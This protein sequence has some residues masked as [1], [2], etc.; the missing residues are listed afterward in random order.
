MKYFNI[1]ELTASPTASRNNIPNTPPDWAIENMKRLISIVLDPARE[2][3]GAAISVNSGYRSPELN[4]KV[5]GARGSYHLQ[6][7]AADLTTGSKSGNIRLYGILSELPHIEL[8]N[9]QNGTW[10]HVAL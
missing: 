5:G 4:A 10:I 9:E 6:G 7:R 2:I 3:Y 1:A 8:I